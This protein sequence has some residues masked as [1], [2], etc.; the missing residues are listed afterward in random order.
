MADEK[1]RSCQVYQQGQAGSDRGS[2]LPSGSVR[3]SDLEVGLLGA[4]IA[5]MNVV[6]VREDS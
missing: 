3:H 2:P 5:G 4:V 6:A 1:C